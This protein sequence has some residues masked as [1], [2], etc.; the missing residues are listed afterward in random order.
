M[1]DDIE[2]FI[3]NNVTNP[4]A[5][6][7]LQKI[8]NDLYEQGSEYDFYSMEE[9]NWSEAIARGIRQV[10]NVR[11]ACNFTGDMYG[12]S[13]EET[14]SKYYA[15]ELE[16]L[17]LYNITD[18]RLDDYDGLEVLEWILAQECF[19]D[20][21]LTDTTKLY[22]GIGCACAAENTYTCIVGTAKHIKQKRVTE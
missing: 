8:H 10:L 1:R 3:D 2:V 18:V 5:K 17:E 19:N 13:I 6:R 11:G 16:G 21:F 9:L 7:R 14:I 4:F 20:D 12:N 15:Y 22:M